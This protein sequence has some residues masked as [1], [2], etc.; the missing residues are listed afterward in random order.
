MTT[1]NDNS[2][3]DRSAF[4]TSIWMLKVEMANA[5]AHMTIDANARLTY[6]RQIDAMA[7]EAARAGPVGEHHLGSGRAAGAGHA[8]R[9]HGSDPWP[10]HPVRAGHGA[11]AQG[12]GQ[13]AQ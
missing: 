8:Q 3:K 10:Q 6:T 5:G 13:D 4:E 11:A 2:A 12:R 9:D 1:D 7:N